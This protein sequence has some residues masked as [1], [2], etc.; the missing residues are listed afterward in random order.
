MKTGHTGAFS[1]LS[2]KRH[3]GFLSAQ[4]S[5]VSPAPRSRKGSKIPR[6]FSSIKT[7]LQIPE[8]GNFSLKKVDEEKRGSKKKLYHLNRSYLKKQSNRR[9][10]DQSLTSTDTKE[11][12][13]L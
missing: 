2:S 4:K 10:R 3:T 11:S 6:P 13:V 12:N 1:P 9:S 8:N 5:P 7:S